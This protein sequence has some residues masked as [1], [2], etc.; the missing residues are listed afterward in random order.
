M[1]DKIRNTIKKYNLA[2]E[3]NGILIGLSGGADSVCLTHA[4]TCLKKELNLRIYTAHVNH[5]LRGLAA[6]ND[7]K[8]AVDFSQ[9]LGIECITVRE[10]VRSYAE[11]YGI[12]EE[13]AGRKLR[14][15]FFERI[16]RE[17]G[18]NKI[19]TAHNKN[20][21]AETIIMNFMRGSL[22]QGLSGIPVRRGDIIRPLLDITRAEIEE[23]CRKNGLLYVTDKTNHEMIYTRNKI[24]LDLIPKIQKEFNQNFIETVTKNAVLLSE[25]NDFLEQT[26]ETVYKNQKDGYLELNLLGTHKAIARRVIVKMMKSAG[27]CDIT[28][29]YVDAVLRLIDNQSGKSVDLPNGNTAKIEYGKL[30]VGRKSEQTPPFEYKIKIGEKTYIKELDITMFAETGEGKDAFKIG[31][32]PEITIRSRRNGDYFYPSGMEGRK[33]L[34]EYFIDSKIPRDI[35][36]KTGILTIDGEIAWVIGRRRDRRFDADR[37]LLIKI[38]K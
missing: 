13:M 24:R 26:A 28:S 2:E 9:S 22:M 30:F 10:D 32:N 37:G 3:N 23:Y 1:L 8:F 5:G 31:E 35:R 36:D 20:D 18:L 33:K 7:E 4:L 14:Y 11:K 15:A 38:L 21:N 34:K 25:E 6:D 12:S 16:M 29:E 19:A 17:Y 27:I